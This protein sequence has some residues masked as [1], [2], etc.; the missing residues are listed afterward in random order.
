MT[1][2]VWSSRAIE[3]TVRRKNQCWFSPLQKKV[4]LTYL[5]ELY[6]EYSSTMRL[7]TSAMKCLNLCSLN[8]VSSLIT[9]TNW[10][11]FILESFDVRKKIVPCLPSSSCLFSICLLL[12]C[13]NLLSYCSTA[14]IAIVQSDSF[15]STFAIIHCITAFRSDFVEACC[16]RR[17]GAITGSSKLLTRKN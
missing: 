10:Q 1:E 15:S 13:L 14:W 6:E 2:T 7:G 4:Y 12:V 16:D 11:R 5:T 9:A 17:V 8:Y 3:M